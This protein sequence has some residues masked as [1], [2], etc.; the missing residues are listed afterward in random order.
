MI[1]IVK[2]PLIVVKSHNFLNRI[3]KTEIE[4]IFRETQQKAADN[5]Q[6]GGSTDGELHNGIKKYNIPLLELKDKS[7]SER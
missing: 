6:Q 4:L 1:F 3:H 5:K 2:V 7:G